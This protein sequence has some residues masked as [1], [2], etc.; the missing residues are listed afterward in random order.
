MGNVEII[1]SNCHQESLLRR[2][3]LYEGF[4]KVGE[5]LFC[6]ACGHRFADESEV[7]FKVAADQPAIFTVADRSKRVDAFSDG[8]A[9]QLC[10]HCAHYL[11]NPFTQFCSVHKKEVQA[12]DSCAQFKVRQA[13][14]ENNTPF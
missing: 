3:A 5:A 11:I 12:T 8:E 1:C 10:R 9:D 6:T 14:N 7:S 2:E 4:S 13:D